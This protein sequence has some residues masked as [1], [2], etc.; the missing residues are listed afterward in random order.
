MGHTYK[1][2]LYRLK[3]SF[4]DSVVSEGLIELTVEDHL[5]EPEFH[6][7]LPRSFKRKKMILQ[8]EQI[9]PHMSVMVKTLID[10]T[11]FSAE[12]AGQ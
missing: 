6:I 12:E 1:K 10:K 9:H 8:K 11:S 2:P 5:N 3:R 4:L 7:Q